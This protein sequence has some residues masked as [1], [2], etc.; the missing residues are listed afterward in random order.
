[1]SSLNNAIAIAS[2]G[3]DAQSLRLR[4]ISEN[5]ANARTV[6]SVAGAEPY[7]RKVV[8][9]AEALD[10]RLPRGMSM[11]SRVDVDTSPFGVEYDPGNPAADERGQVALP[12]VNVLV[13]LAD[14]RDANRTY[15]ANLQVVKQSSTLIGSVVA[16]LR[17]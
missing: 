11:S 4:V 14:M 7:R 12:N 8:T 6:G 10:P 13:E 16:L 17:E 1:M 2:V 9:F 3:I 15:E 5:I